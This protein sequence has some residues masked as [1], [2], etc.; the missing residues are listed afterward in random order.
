M[1]AETS[2]AVVRAAYLPGQISLYRH[3]LAKR[4]DPTLPDNP[5]IYLIPLGT[6]LQQLV[7]FAALQQGITFLAS[8]TEAI[9]DVNL[10]VRPVVGVNLFETPAFPPEL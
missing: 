3:D 5:H 1:L 9:P 10:L 2:A 6:P 4:I 7:G 8:P